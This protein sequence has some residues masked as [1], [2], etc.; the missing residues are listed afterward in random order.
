MNVDTILDALNR[1]GVDYLLIGGM[2]FMLRH[3][4]ILT[5]DLDIWIDDSPDNRRRCET[6]L[7]ELQAQWGATDDAWGPVADLPHDWLAA[8]DV[9]CLS[10]PHGAIDIF[11]NVEGLDDWKSSWDNG[12][13]ESTSTGVPYRGLSD[14][15]MLGCQLAL[16]VGLQKQE[17]IRH[18]RDAIDKKRNRP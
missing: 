18:L 17:R 1:H 3:Q 12:I 16:D 4:P 11:R 10:S 13:D 5:Y 2:N 15:D 8:Q 6:A 9:F 7:A 14:E